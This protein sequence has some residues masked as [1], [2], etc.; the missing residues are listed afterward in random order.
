MSF[1]TRH[2]PAVLFTLLSLSVSLCA[3]SS[4]KEP[5]KVPHGSISGKVTIKDKGVPGVSIG[6]RK[7]D[8]SSPFEGFQRATTDQNGFYR[9]ANLAAGSYSVFAVMPAFVA[10]DIR[11]GKQKTVVVG[12]GET[13]E[14]I[15]FAL[16]RGGVISGRITDAD[17]R[18][19]IEQQVYVYS[20]A[21][22]QQQRVQ[23]TVYATSSARTDDRGVYR[24][25]GL[26]TG[27][28]NVAV[29]RA[30]DDLSVTYSQSRVFYK[31]TFYPDVT[32]QAKATVIQ[33]TEGSEADNV[34]I[35]VGRAVQTFSASGQLMDETGQP[36]PN[37]RFGLQQQL[38]QRI[39]FNTNTST[40]ANSQG[41]FV[42]EGLVPGRYT[43]FLFPNASNEL[44][45]ENFTF[46]I[47]DHDLTNLVVKLARG[48]S[49]TGTVVLENPDQAIFD[50]LL[51]L[52]LR[53]IGV[54]SIGNGATYGSS[55]SSPIGPDGSFRVAGLPSGKINMLFAATGTPLPPKGFLITRVEREGVV[56]PRGLE[57]KDGEQVTG[58]RVFVSAGSATLR[59]VVT[60]DNGPLPDKGR[61]SVRITKQG[62]TLGNV[63]PA[64]VDARGRFLLDT[65]PPGTY[66]VMVTVN[67]YGQPPRNIMRKV[68][69]QDEQT[70]DVTIN[71]DTTEQPKPK[72]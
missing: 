6:L 35:T 28:Y 16:V 15:D 66:D 68:T 42:V 4:N 37:L 17:G 61:V 5:A 30:A 70:M 40:S 18:P 7:G 49:I 64:T 47:V 43:V 59:G 53:A 71:V 25:F 10:S 57:V 19:V 8:N 24:V 9:L 13:V 48:V 39:E 20:A 27:R 41:E 34:D 36:V 23:R 44:R 69:L 55:A 11:D 21:M 2:L 56:L 12:E 1:F 14:D 45:V 46:D 33:V 62:A 38:G 58:V 3:Q 60:V 26:T 52:Q 31:Q 63:R 22:F 54:I 29:G 32:E 51:Q 67:L 65:I 50:K 72:Q